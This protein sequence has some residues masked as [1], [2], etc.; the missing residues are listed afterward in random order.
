MMTIAQ[1][2]RQEG[3]QEGRQQGRQEGRQEGRREARLEMIRTMLANGIDQRKI[4]S[5]FGLTEEELR[6]LRH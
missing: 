5:M 6:Q 1:K 2:L 4:S 3:R